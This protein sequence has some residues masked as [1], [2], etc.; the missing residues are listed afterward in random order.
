MKKE[1]EVK[2]KVDDFKDLKGKI[3]NLGCTFSE[4]IF[5]D[6]TIFINYNRPFLEFTPNEAK[7]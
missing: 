6:D 2:F 5:Q 3:E 1:I 4:P 7:K